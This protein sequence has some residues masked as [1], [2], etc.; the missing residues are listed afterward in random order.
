MNNSEKSKPL[1]SH[2]R[3][4]LEVTVII[5]R[6]TFAKLLQCVCVCVCV[7]EMYD[8]GFKYTSKQDYTLSALFFA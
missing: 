5:L 8:L 6:H 3:F 7:C 2:H 4:L 1:L